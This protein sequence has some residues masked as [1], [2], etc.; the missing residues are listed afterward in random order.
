[1]HEILR[2]IRAAI[3]GEGA[4]II[5]HRTTGGGHQRLD[6]MVG[7]HA[8]FFVFAST[9]RQAKDRKAISNA[10]RVVRR[11]TLSQGTPFSL[12]GTR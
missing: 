5:A 7:G 10:R 8:G 2:H 9:P 3:E 4:T 12:R 6:F 11:I 1:M